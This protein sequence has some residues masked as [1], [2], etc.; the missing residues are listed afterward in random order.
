M[1]EQTPIHAPRE[2]TCI[3]GTHSHRLVRRNLSVYKEHRGTGSHR[4]DD[5][6]RLL[7]EQEAGVN[8]TN[9]N[10]DCVCGEHIVL[11]NPKQ[12]DKTK[13][14]KCSREYVVGMRPFLK[15]V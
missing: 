15:P 12:G 1:P 4:N 6:K 9:Y 2:C 14:H 11:T 7:R 8:T 3:D 13:C 10:R 5:S